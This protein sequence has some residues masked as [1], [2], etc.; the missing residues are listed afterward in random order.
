MPPGFNSV[1]A[2]NTFFAVILVG[3]A[4]RLLSLHMV[5]SSNKS[6]HDLGTAMAFQY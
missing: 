4:W 2:L 3:T 5:A 1:V 6:V